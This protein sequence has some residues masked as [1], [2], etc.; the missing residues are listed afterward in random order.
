MDKLGI[1]VNIRVLDA[2]AYRGRMNNYDFDMTLYYWL[3]SLSP[4]TEQ[5]LY[6]GCQAANEPARWNFPGICNPAIDAIAAAVAQAKSRESLVAHIRALDRIL[7]WER[8]MIPLYYSGSDYFSYKNNVKHPENT[9]IYGAVLE[10]WW[11]D[12]EGE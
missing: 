2:A 4:G 8:Y 10:T 12:Q 7:M 9:P 1:N 5:I 3:S 6:Y 11:M